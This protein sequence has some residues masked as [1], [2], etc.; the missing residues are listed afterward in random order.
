M[1][2]C[3]PYLETVAAERNPVAVTELNVDILRADSG[4]QTDF[5]ARFL[6]H[7]PGAR[8]MIRVAMCVDRVQKFQ[9]E[10]LNQR[11][12]AARLLEHGIDDDRLQG[13]M[14]SDDVRICR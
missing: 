6:R 4:R 8:Y 3:R 13:V 7:K 1:T 12:I 2:R 14:V 10:F 5:A 9:T 11:K